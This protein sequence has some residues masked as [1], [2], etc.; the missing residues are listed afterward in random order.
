MG[1]VVWKKVW[2]DNYL[3]E[4]QIVQHFLQLRKLSRAACCAGLI[5]MIV[6]LL[7]VRISCGCR[8]KVFSSKCRVFRRNGKIYVC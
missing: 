7:H 6:K 5:Y 4:V 2:N 3:L 1:H 8:P